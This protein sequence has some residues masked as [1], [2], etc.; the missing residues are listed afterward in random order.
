MTLHAQISLALLVLINIATLV[1]LGR[2]WTYRE[3]GV[4]AWMVASTWSLLLADG[5]FLMAVFGFARGRWAEYAYLTF[6]D[7]RIVVQSWLFWM[8]LRQRRR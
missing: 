1:K 5:L 6:L 7:L 2:P 4:A 8:I 3:R